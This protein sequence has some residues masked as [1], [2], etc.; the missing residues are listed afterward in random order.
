M[1][2]SASS[3]P[4]RQAAAA[5]V[6]LS[7]PASGTN[8]GSLSTVPA[9]SHSRRC[10]YLAAQGGQTHTRT[11]HLRR[12]PAFALHP[13]R[14][15]RRGADRLAI[16]EVQVQDSKHLSK[17]LRNL[18]CMLC[19]LHHTTLGRFGFSS[20]DTYCSSKRCSNATKPSRSARSRSAVCRGIIV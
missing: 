18:R 15:L 6:S 3:V 12:R 2:A 1:V 9:M 8:S 11:Q 17:Q 13:E 19:V 16:A 5:S 20:T 14:R 10:V 4:L 7:G